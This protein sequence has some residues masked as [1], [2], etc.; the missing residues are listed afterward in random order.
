M[1][2][3]IE[4][5]PELT[6]LLDNWKTIRKEAVQV[7]DAMIDL[8][9]WRSKNGKW[10]I[11]PLLLEEEDE[12]LLSDDIVKACRELVPKTIEIVE[13]IPNLQSFAF[14]M[15]APNGY[16]MAHRHG[17]PFVSA[18]LCLQDGGKNALIV[19]E[20]TRNLNDGEIAVFDYRKMH[21]VYNWGDD[22][23]IALIVSLNKKA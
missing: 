9:D 17:N 2:E 20:E 4:N 8:G 10:K 14:S 5:Y 1:F 11:F 6:I 22:S 23:R 18:S 15:V 7:V 13:Q 3:P 21:A 16:I 12:K 19:E